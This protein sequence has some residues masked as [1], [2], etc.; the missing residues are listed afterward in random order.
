MKIKPI[1]VTALFCVEFL[2][3]CGKQPPSTIT[4]TRS[5][6]S[7]PQ[8]KSVYVD[9]QAQVAELK[10]RLAGDP[11]SAFLHNQIAVAYNALGDS[12]NSDREIRI[13]MK[14]NPDDP[15]D[16]YTAFAFYQQ[17]HL[18]NKEMS[19]LKKALEIDP[20]NAFGH[21]ERAGLLEDEKKW[22]DALTEYQATKRLADWVKANPDN[23][24]NTVWTYTDRRGNPYDITWEISHVDDDLRRVNAEILSNSS[25]GRHE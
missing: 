5:T 18:K 20:G 22:T 8:H 13:A 19:V 7:A 23:F 3:A 24:K 25:P 6:N 10:K 17:R 4:N 1:L 11:N 12:P 2:F 16:C 9:W 15:S 14:L 21:Y